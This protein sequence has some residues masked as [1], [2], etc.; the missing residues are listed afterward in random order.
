SSRTGPASC[1]EAR[2]MRIASGGPCR[3][4]SSASTR[5]TSPAVYDATSRALV[6]YLPAGSSLWPLLDS[7][8]RAVAVCRREERARDN[9]VMPREA[10]GPLPA[11]CHEW[12]AQAGLGSEKGGRRVHSQPAVPIPE[13]WILPVASPQQVHRLVNLRVPYTPLPSAF[14][15]FVGFALLRCAACSRLA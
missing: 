11:G 3:A 1:C 5:A 9:S 12:R 7:L 6:R 10:S 14:R 4:K 15:S 8:L 13:F 2:S